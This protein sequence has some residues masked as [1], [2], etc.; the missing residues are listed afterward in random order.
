MSGE[1]Q[2]SSTSAL[3]RPSA[4]PSVAAGDIWRVRGAAI[5]RNA[6]LRDTVGVTNAAED[7]PDVIVGGSRL[8]HILVAYP[9]VR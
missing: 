3:S 6:V 9:Q 7:R 1:S 4:A 8:V 2:G 5:D